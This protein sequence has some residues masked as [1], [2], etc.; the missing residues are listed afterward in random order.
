M[1]FKV[2]V[3]CEV[4]Y[5]NNVFDLVTLNSFVYF[6][7]LN[8]SIIIH[9]HIGA[10]LHWIIPTLEHTYTGA[11][12]QRRS[13]HELLEYELLEYELGRVQAGGL[14]EDELHHHITQAT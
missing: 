4:Q 9:I 6:M 1:R 5:P 7:S 12:L 2:R 3:K 13:T 8:T 14:V 11:H 10:H